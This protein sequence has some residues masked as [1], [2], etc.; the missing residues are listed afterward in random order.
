VYEDKWYASGCGEFSAG[1]VDSYGAL[2]IAVPADAT[3]GPVPT[4][5]STL[6]DGAFAIVEAAG[7][8]RGSASQ[9]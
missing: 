9:A 8:G 2:A 6:A 3:E 7:R 1:V 4:E 5:L